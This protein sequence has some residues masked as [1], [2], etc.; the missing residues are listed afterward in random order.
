MQHQISNE[1]VDHGDIIIIA[2]PTNAIRPVCAEINAMI[3][4]PK[5]F[6]HVSKGIEPNSLK[7]I[8]EMIAE[9]IS[10]SNSKG[11]VALSGPSH[12]EEVVNAIRLL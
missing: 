5:L 9:E 1:A 6:V 4:E 7:R 3:T 8:S 11:I 2:V 10:R 12:A